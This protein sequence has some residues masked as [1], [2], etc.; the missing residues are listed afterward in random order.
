[1]SSFASARSDA[2]GDHSVERLPVT[3]D[4]K[5][6][7]HAYTAISVSDE[8]PCDK[9]ERA[10]ESPGSHPSTTSADCTRDGLMVGRQN[11]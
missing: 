4:P 7:R 3:S 11:L 9:A 8:G 2:S 5:L 6:N 1:M 10:K